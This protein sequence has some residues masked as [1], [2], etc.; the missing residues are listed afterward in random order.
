MS[1]TS[2][3]VATKNTWNLVMHKAKIFAILVIFVAISCYIV[4]VTVS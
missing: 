4:R 3:F 2:F 1:M